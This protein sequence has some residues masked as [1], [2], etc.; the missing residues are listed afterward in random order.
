[1][2]NE[3]EVSD[4]EAARRRK[5]EDLRQRGVNPYPND[6]RPTATAAEIHAR[7]GSKWREELE[8]GDYSVGTAGR[9]VGLRSFGK[10]SFI[11]LQ[12]RSGKIQVYVK[13]DG[14]GEAAY[15]D[16]K[17]YYPQ[18]GSLQAEVGLAQIA[19]AKK[20]NDEAKTKLE[21]IMDAALKEKVIVPGNALAYSQA[22]LL[23]GQI[24]E[25]EGNFA[26]SLE[27]YLRTVTLFYHD[28]TAVA[29]AQE[30]S[31]AL[32]KANKDL[33]VP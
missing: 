24:K 28:R 12:D 32:R 7:F 33:H 6:F 23:S 18:G 31:D 21:P 3:I 30:R 9:I 25:A 4:L 8:G 17:K 5:L 22:F 11:H 26:G 14:I 16:F 19:F 27:D 2:P 13:R 29:F 10:A 20:Q 1:M 15:A